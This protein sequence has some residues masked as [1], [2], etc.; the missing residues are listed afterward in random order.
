MMEFDE[1]KDQICVV[2]EF[3]FVFDAIIDYKEVW[4]TLYSIK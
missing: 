4:E 1:Q 2:Q 3:I